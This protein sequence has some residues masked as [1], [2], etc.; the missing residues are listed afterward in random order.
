MNESGGEEMKD[1]EVIEETVKAED[2]A[3]VEEIAGIAYF[4][5]TTVAASIT[6]TS[7]ISDGGWT[8][9]K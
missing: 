3:T 1:E 8:S 4:L 2:E 7:I 6:G 5:T 9:G